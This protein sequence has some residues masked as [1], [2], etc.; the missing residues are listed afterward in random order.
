[1]HDPADNLILSSVHALRKVTVW[2]KL[3]G[4]RI[5]VNGVIDGIYQLVVPALDMAA[6]CGG[7][8]ATV[9]VYPGTAEVPGWLVH[10]GSASA[11]SIL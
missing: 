2:D 9:T 3:K 8:L 7:A 1:M 11:E 5:T 6:S 4:I 10:Q